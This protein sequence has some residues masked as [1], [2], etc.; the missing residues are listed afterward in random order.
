MADVIRSSRFKKQFRKKTP[1][2]QA[3]VLQTIQRL[4]DDPRHPGL[5]THQVHG[6]PGV[7]EAYVNDANRVTFHRE[8]GSIV[9][10]NNCVHDKVLGK[11]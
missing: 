6:H 3:S 1:Q 4:C 9:F 8:E 2:M 7:W 10:R 5:N 11:P